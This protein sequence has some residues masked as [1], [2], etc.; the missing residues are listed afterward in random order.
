M[1]AQQMSLQPGVTAARAGQSRLGDTGQLGHSPA[2]AP[3]AVPRCP[4]GF[5]G[6]AREGWDGMGPFLTCGP[7][8]GVRKGFAPAVGPL[9][10][11]EE[12]PEGPRK[13]GDIPWLGCDTSPCPQTCCPSVSPFPHPPT[14]WETRS[15]PAP[16]VPL[17]PQ[18]PSQQPN[19]GVPLAL[20]GPQASPRPARRPQ[21]LGPGRGVF[22]WSR[23]QGGLLPSPREGRCLTRLRPG[24]RGCAGDQTCGLLPPPLPPQHMGPCPLNPSLPFGGGRSA[25]SRCFPK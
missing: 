8:W 23:R 9:E 21:L 5:W 16:P 20:G 19:P 3:R 14:A 6:P 10:E 11:L 1:G 4:A 22:S 15:I 25:D 18:G 24:S 12:G 13:G 7:L 2:H 17:G